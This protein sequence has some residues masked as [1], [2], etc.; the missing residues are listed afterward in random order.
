MSRRNVKALQRVYEAMARGDFW[1]AR[2]VFAPDIEWRWSP[3]T[4]T[5]TGDRTYHGIEG[6]EAATRDWLQAW[7][8]FW[9]EAE[10]FIDAG[11]AIVVITRT[12]GRP[13]GGDREIE[14]ALAEVWTFRDDKAIRFEGFDSREDA[15][16]AVG[17]AD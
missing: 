10:E 7:D 2:Q 17:L 11:D 12:H 9:Q 5:L 15:L 6:V 4:S 13:K 8:R 1:A 16:R 3:S 14:A